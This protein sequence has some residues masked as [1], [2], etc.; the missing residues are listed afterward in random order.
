M[1]NSGSGAFSGEQNQSPSALPYPH[2]QH[3]QIGDIFQSHAIRRYLC[4]LT[5]PDARTGLFGFKACGSKK[6]RQRGHGLA[7]QPVGYGHELIASL[8]HLRIRAVSPLHHHQLNHLRRQLDIR[9]LK[10]PLNEDAA[11]LARD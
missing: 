8:N 3:A 9:G 10:R 11:I 6:Q 4:H 1:R 2:W 5:E 7:P